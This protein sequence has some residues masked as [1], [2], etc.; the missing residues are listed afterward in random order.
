M[1]VWKFRNP[2][3]LIQI[4]TRNGYKVVKEFTDDELYTTLDGRRLRSVN[5]YEAI[6]VW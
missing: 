5:Y 3:I 6:S 2:N 4:N 1:R